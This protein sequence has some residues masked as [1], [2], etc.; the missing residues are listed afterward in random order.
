MSRLYRPFFGV[1]VEASPQLRSAIWS[2]TEASP[3]ADVRAKGHSVM[4]TMS[5]RNSIVTCEV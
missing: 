4:H 1:A 5:Q 3:V 2:C